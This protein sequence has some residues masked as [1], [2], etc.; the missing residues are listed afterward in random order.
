LVHII[1]SIVGGTPT[2]RGV[3]DGSTGV[4]V[5]IAVDVG[6]SDGISVGL[7][8]WVGMGVELVGTFVIVGEDTG[9]RVGVLVKLMAFVDVGIFDSP[10]V[11]LAPAPV[12]VTSN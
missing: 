2:D 4:S 1:L 12:T 11:W 9:T 6:T 3:G 8:T 7:I 5:P 10:K